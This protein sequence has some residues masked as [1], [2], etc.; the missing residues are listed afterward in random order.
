M[1]FDETSIYVFGNERIYF[2]YSEFLSSSFNPVK[3]SSSI[4]PLRHAIS[5][6]HASILL[7]L[8]CISLINRDASSKPS[9]VP[10]SNHFVSFNS[11]ATNLFRFKYS[12]NT[13]VISFS[14]L[15]ERG[16]FLAIPDAA[17]SKKIQ[18]WNSQMR[19][20]FCRFFLY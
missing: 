16:I 14:P 13:E 8:C 9:G 10:V 17:L 18:P 5:S 7:F 3:V 12:C 2:P 19:F 15:G 6:M 11:I 1:V 4:H 20:R